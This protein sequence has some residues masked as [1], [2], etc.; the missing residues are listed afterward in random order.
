MLFLDWNLGPTEVNEILPGFCGI[1][2]L[3]LVSSMVW[4]CLSFQSSVIT[5][6]VVS[7]QKKCWMTLLP[8]IRIIRG[9]EIGLAGYRKRKA[10]LMVSRTISLHGIA[11]KTLLS[12]QWCSVS[13]RLPNFY[14][15]CGPRLSAAGS[16]AETL[17]IPL[18]ELSTL[19]R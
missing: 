10:H 17:A 18:G 12:P 5:V 4:D 19:P 7:C 16:E 14:F 1:I 13:H 3:I 6:E 2:F 9:I 8:V 15:L 11:G